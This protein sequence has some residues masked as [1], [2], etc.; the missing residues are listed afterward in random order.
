M[1][2]LVIFFLAAFLFVCCN[3]NQTAAP[4]GYTVTGTAE[5]CTDGDTVYLCRMEGFLD[6]VPTDTTVVRGGQFRFEGKADGAQLRFVVPTHKGS[7]VAMTVMVL[8][9]AD[10]HVALTAGGRADSI[11]GG[12]SQALYE[13][14]LDGS[15]KI[16]QQLQMA[17]EVANDTVATD[18]MRLNAE[19]TIDSLMEVQTNYRKQFIISHIPSAASDLIFGQCEHDFSD[20]DRDELLRLLGEQQPQ[21]P[22]YRAA[23][24][25]KKVKSGK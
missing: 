10:I 18:R 20:A 1:R 21:Y 2:T 24:E 4:E 6:V 11:K 3:S 9:N 22:A 5:G 17:W 14:F 19:I 16:S 7:A 15:T 23:M 13:E 12:P 25:E 8:E